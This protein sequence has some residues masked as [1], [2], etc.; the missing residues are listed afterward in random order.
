MSNTPEKLNRYFKRTVDHIHRVQLNMVKVVTEF[1]D[2]INLSDEDCRALMFSVMKHD[3][4]KFNEIQFLP[5]V[6]LTEYYHQRKVLGNKDYN[7]ANTQVIDAVNAAVHDHYQNENHHLEKGDSKSRLDLIE[8]VC[9]LQAMAQEFNEGT[10]RG[11]F[12][13]VWKKKYSKEIVDDF[14]SMIEVMDCVIR[15]FESDHNQSMGRV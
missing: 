4:S 8:I 11:Y 14:E 1:R 7:Y 10:C 3:R 13:N 15:C 12:E 2:R 9:D 6:E 5:Y